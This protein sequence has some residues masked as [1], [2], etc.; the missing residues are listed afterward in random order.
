MKECELVVV[1]EIEMQKTCIEC[2]RKFEG[3]NNR[4]RCD[5]CQ[6]EYRKAYKNEHQKLTQPKSA[7]RDSEMWQYSKF[8]KKCSKDEIRLLFKKLRNDMKGLDTSNPEHQK[9]IK[10]KRTQLAILRDTYRMQ[11]AQEQDIQDEYDAF[12]DDIE[13][14]FEEGGT[15]Y[16]DWIFDAPLKRDK[17]K[18]TAE[19]AYEEFYLSSPTNTESE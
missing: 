15:A 3:S 4:K 2:G 9:I 10:K 8:V 16:D 5:E 14:A 19:E 18:L 12:C 17:R 13:R 6:K 11:D 1:Q 7:R